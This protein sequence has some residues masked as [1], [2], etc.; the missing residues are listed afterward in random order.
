MYASTKNIK[1][2]ARQFGLHYT[3]LGAHAKCQKRGSIFCI[4]RTKELQHCKRGT[5]TKLQLNTKCRQH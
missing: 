3:F 2:L 4:K 1:E 5:F